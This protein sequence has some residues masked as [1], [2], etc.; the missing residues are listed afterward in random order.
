MAEEINR[1]ITNI[2]DLAR[3]AKGESQQAARCMPALVAE[4]A[5]ARGLAEWFMA[6]GRGSAAA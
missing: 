6:G 2:K 5:R 1:W 4:A 3:E